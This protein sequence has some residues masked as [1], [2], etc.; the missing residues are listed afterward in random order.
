MDPMTAVVSGGIIGGVNTTPK[1]RP[2]YKCFTVINP[3]LDQGPAASAAEPIIAMKGAGT[4]GEIF[5][6]ILLNKKIIQK[7]MFVNQVDE[8]Y[9]HYFEC[10][11]II[12][13][14]R[15]FQ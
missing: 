3:T 12:T 2:P 15:M 13:Q 10:M 4:K 9:I 1:G 7:M 11:L 5:L 6:Q 8:T 14:M